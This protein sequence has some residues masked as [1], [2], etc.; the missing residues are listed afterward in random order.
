MSRKNKVVYSNIQPNTKEAGIWVN[1]DDGNI[2]I[3]K[4]GKWVDDGGNGGNAEAS[5]IEYLDVR[6]VDS[7]ILSALLNCSM[8]DK[9]KAETL[10][11]TFIGFNRQSVRDIV[12]EDTI[13]KTLAV[14]VN[15]NDFI[16]VN[17]DGQIQ[18]FTI[19]DYLLISATQEELAAIPRITK[20]QFYSL[21]S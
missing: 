15:M 11:Y 6:D 16:I 3:E 8:Y 17:M 4:D 5:S 14:A 20:E 1:T 2:K 10:N 12:G 21:E 18:N 7:G 19:K 9:I 13:T